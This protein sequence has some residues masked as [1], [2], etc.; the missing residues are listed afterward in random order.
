MSTWAASLI[1]DPRL[2]SAGKMSHVSLAP[3]FF[4]L[5]FASQISATRSVGNALGI[6]STNTLIVATVLLV[7]AIVCFIVSLCVAS[8]KQESNPD[9]I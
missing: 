9:L 1:P 6:E 2:R 8:G 5:L 4:V 7:A 3:F